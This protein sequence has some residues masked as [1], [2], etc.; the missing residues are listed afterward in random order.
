MQ[1]ISIQ[2][3]RAAAALSVTI[4]HGQAFIGFPMEK[5]GESYNWS[6][7]LP[8]GAGVDLFFVISGFIMVYASERLFAQPGA[9]GVFA[10]R[11]LTRIAPLYWTAT[12]LLL[13]RDVVK[14]QFGWDAADL[15][16]SFLFI[17]WDTYH[18]GVPRPIYSLGW[19]LNYEM[20]FYATFALFIGARREVAVALVTAFLSALVLLGSVHPFENPMLLVWT[21]PIVFEFVFGMGLALLARRGF[22]LPGPAR[23]L[24]IV[25]AVAALLWDFLDSPSH[26]YDWMTP[27]DFAR[28]F[29]WGV[30][31]A[32]LVAAVV[33][34]SAWAGA[35]SRVTR[36]GVTLG[37]AS[38]ALYLCHPIVMAPFARGW[39]FLGADRLLPA[40]A[41]VAVEVGLS[42]IVALAIYRWFERPTTRRLQGLS[43]ERGGK[44]AAS[45]EPRALI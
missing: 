39:F 1:L 15:V 32:M 10:W 40:R 43:W 33:L 35:S 27:N 12:A 23:G 8:W 19:T 44:P 31:A 6:H 37:D 22:T 21:Q 4:G 45:A 36:A 20:F 34:K 11:R 13:A 17:P 30:P 25:A 2:L 5:L 29:A 24:L 9:T 41:G 16:T 3:L 7:L 18:N 26:P 14:R 38:Y 42:V 28:V